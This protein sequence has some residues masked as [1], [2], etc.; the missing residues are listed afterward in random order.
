[1]K[2]VPPFSFLQLLVFKEVVEAGGVHQA[3]N[4]LFMAQPTVSKHLRELESQMGVGL[5]D[6]TSRPHRLTESG[7]L[8]YQFCQ[9]MELDIENFKNKLE[10]LGKGHQG[11][12]SIGANTAPGNY[13]LPI[14]C[15][16]FK[17]IHPNVQF[18][19]KVA[20]SEDI[21]SMLLNNKLQFGVTTGQAMPPG[22]D[23]I[24]LLDEPLVAICRINHP[25]V[26][27][28]TIT[29]EELNQYPYVVGLQNSNVWR[30]VA[31][32]WDSL[33]AYP[34][35]LM[36]ISHVEG[37]KKVVALSD[38]I[39]IIPYA[40]A[41]D[42]IANGWL[43]PLPL[44]VEKFHTPFFLIKKTGVHLSRTS[45]NFINYV[46]E[47]VAEYSSSRNIDYFNITK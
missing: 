20:D 47:F 39:A 37:L 41:R 46:K 44:N 45:N 1:M 25:L 35:V 30:I 38:G 10:S 26:G 27:K 34:K 6:R 3:A 40:A 23:A 42:E 7:E 31:E 11:T 24:H 19:I 18:T 4:S 8:L 28:E 22:L 5:F 17:K 13:F 43:Y 15:L 29:L 21:Y 16:N 2:S 36:Q 32:V 33:G 9:Q 12:I 14:I